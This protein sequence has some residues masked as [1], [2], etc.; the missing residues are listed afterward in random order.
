MDI[1]FRH[2]NY[3]IAVAE[4]RSFNKGASRLGISQPTLT[5]QL[6]ELEKG[7]QVKLF[8]RSPFG[9]TLTGAGSE[10]FLHSRSLMDE[11]RDMNLEMRSFADGHIRIGYIAPSLF[12]PVGEA[13]AETRR[14]FPEAALEILEAA[15]ARQIDLLQQGKI[16]VAFLGHCSHSFSDRLEF[17]PLYRIPLAAVLPSNHILAQ[18]DSLSLIQLSRETFLGLKEELFPG[19]QAIVAR[20]CEESGFQI[21]YGQLADSLISLLSLIGHG[22]GVSLVPQDAS[23]IAHPQVRFVP[24]ENK[25]AEIRFHAAHRRG[26][27]CPKLSTLLDLCREFGGS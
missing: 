16:D 10:F 20:I 7:L 5:R 1:E 13:I 8:D 15:P 4:E 9:V 27:N 3:F 24:L 23:S 17:L 22:Q 2:L 6:N 14:R 26:M 25:T 21:T 19:R 18:S 11:H 12:G